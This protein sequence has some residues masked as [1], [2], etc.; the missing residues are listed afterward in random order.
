MR[1]GICVAV[2][3]CVSLGFCVSVHA[4]GKKRAEGSVNKTIQGPGGKGSAQVK[5]EMDVKG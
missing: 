3:V 4:Q 1:T 2:M 5:G